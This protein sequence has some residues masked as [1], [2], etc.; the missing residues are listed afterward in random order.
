MPRLEAVLDKQLVGLLAREDP[1][2]AR[3][4]VRGPA[5]RF[6]ARVVAADVHRSHPRLADSTVLQAARQQ[7]GARAE[8]LLGL[9][10][11]VGVAALLRLP[12]RCRVMPRLRVLLRHGRCG[13]RLLLKLS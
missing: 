4:R 8:L 11:D 1:L 10:R 9:A 13:C 12:G 2:H 6:V 5:V 3:L 7:P